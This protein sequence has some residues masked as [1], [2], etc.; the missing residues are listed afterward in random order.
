[1]AFLELAK[2]RYSLRQFSDRPVEKEKLEQILEAGRVAPTACNNQP[3][4]I[5][6]LEGGEALAK[7]K[8]CTPYTFGAPVVLAVCYDSAQSWKRRYDGKDSGDVDAAIVGAHLMLE[9]ADLGLGTTWVGSFDPAAFRAEFALPA[10]VVPVALFPLGYAAPGA[11]PNGTNHFSRKPLKE[12]VFY[13]H[14]D[15]DS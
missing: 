1:M 5:L 8:K 7:L 15:G 10:S 9:A 3:Q 12:T 14:F 11:K 13:G 6:V 2:E 4:K